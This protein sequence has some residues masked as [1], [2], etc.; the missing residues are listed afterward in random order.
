MSKSCGAW[1]SDGRHVLD[2]EDGE[3]DVFTSDAEQVCVFVCLCACLLGGHLLAPKTDTDMRSPL[4]W[5]SHAVAFP[6]TT[7]HPRD[8]TASQPHR[9]LLSPC[10][11]SRGREPFV[12]HKRGL[13][14]EASQ[15]HVGTHPCRAVQSLEDAPLFLRG[16]LPLASA[17]SGLVVVANTALD[18]LDGSDFLCHTVSSLLF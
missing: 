3:N 6:T 14:L 15:R 9:A 5:H 16:A 7:C 10:H 13:V 8:R 18:A 4:H 12:L 2:H 11:T 17:I 1:Q